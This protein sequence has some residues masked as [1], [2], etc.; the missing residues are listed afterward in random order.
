MKRLLTLL[1][2]CLLTCMVIGQQTVLLNEDFNSIASG[3]PSGWNNTEGTITGLNAG[4]NAYALSDNEGCIRF[5]SRNNLPGMTNMLKTPSMSFAQGSKMVL[6]FKYKKPNGGDFSIF[7][8]TDGGATYPNVLAN[9]LPLADDWVNKEYDL[10]G[11]AGNNN[12]KIVFKGTSNSGTGDAYIYLDDVVVE[13]APRCQEPTDMTIIGISPTSATLMWTLSYGG[14]QPGQFIITVT[15][16]NG[17]I[18]MQDSTLAVTPQSGAYYTTI[19]GL[20]ANTT[21]NVELQ[22]D[23]DAEYAGFSKK[24]TMTFATICESQALPYS[25]DFNNSAIPLCTTSHNAS[26]Y[27]QMLRLN[28]T[29]ASDA[30]IIFP[31]VAESAD[32]LEIDYRIRQDE[33]YETMYMVGIITDPADI[34]TFAPVYYGTLNDDD[35]HDIRFNTIG[36]MDPISPVSVCFYFGSGLNTTIYM[37][38]VNIHMAPGCFRPENPKVSNVTKNSATVEWEENGSINYTISFSAP[39]DT[40]TFTS[41]TSPY[42]ATGL[43]PNTHYTVTITANCG[44]DGNS[45][46]SRAIEIT[47]PC[48]IAVNA[49]FTEGFETGMIPD[50]WTQGSLTSDTCQ[51]FEASATVRHSG[52][53]AMKMKVMPDR[54]MSYLASQALPI[55]SAN[56]HQVT[57]WVNRDNNDGQPEEGI[58]I[59]ESQSNTSVANATLLGFIPRYYAAAPAEESAGWHKYSFSI[60]QSGTHYILIEGVHKNG[61]ELYFDDMSVELIPTCRPIEDI[62]SITTTTN[63]ATMSWT[64]NGTENQWIVVYNVINGSTQVAHDSTLVNTPSI[65]I[66][67]LDMGTDYS[68]SGSIY[69]Y[70]S[71]T[72]RSEKF[73]YSKNFST[74]CQTKQVPYVE[75]FE[76]YITNNSIQCWDISSSTTPTASTAATKCQ[77]FGAYRDASKESEQMVMRLEN[78][79]T[80]AGIA[81]AISPVI[82]LNAGTQY[83]VTF[84]F[85]NNMSR[86]R[87][88]DFISPV[89]KISIDNGVTFTV[90]DSLRSNMDSYMEYEKDL[91]AYAGHNVIFAFES[92]VSNGF[93]KLLIDNFQVTLKPLCADL[94]I[95]SISNVTSSS[96]Q[97]NITDN[98]GTAWEISY[99]TKGIQAGMGTTVSVTAGMNSGNI[100]GLTPQTEYDVYV[101]RNCGNEYGNWSRIPIRFTTTCIATTVPILEDFERIQSGQLKGCFINEVINNGAVGVFTGSENNHTIGGFNGI[102]GTLVS[103]S[104]SPTELSTSLSL[105][106]YVTLEAGKNYE[107][108]L[109]AKAYMKQNSLLDYNIRFKYGTLIDQANEIA[110]INVN[111]INWAKA[112]AYFTVPTDGDY[113]VGFTT[114]SG[115]NVTYYFIADDYSLKEVNCIPPTSAFISALA[116]NTA[117]ISIV[118]NASKYEVRVSDTEPD[119]N[120]EISG[121]I[122]LDAKCTSGIVNLTNLVPN[123][124]YYYTVRSICSDNV[125]SSEWL[126]VQTFHTRCGA[127][128]IPYTQDFESESSIS[129]WSTAGTGTALRVNNMHHSG[130]SSYKVN[131]LMLISP[132]F[133]TQTLAGNTFSG[134]VNTSSSCDVTIGLMNDPED[135]TSYAEVEKVHV[136]NNNMWTE[137]NVPLNLPADPQ[138]DDYRGAQY[139]V[140]ITE[141]GVTAYFDQFNFATTPTCAKPKDLT[142][143]NITTTS[144]M[145]DWAPQGTET[146]W[147]L[148][149]LS[150]KGGEG[151]KHIV[152]SHPYQLTGLNPGTTYKLYLKAVCSAQDISEETVSDPYSTL[153]GT[154]TPPFIEDFE[155]HDI[156]R[157]P[158]CWDTGSSTTPSQSSSYL[159][160]VFSNSSNK[161]AR[162][163]NQWVKAGIAELNTP[164]IALAAGSQ[165]VLQFD[166]AHNATCSDLAIEV[167]EGAQKTLI[168][169]VAPSGIDSEKTP[170]GFSTYSYD[171]SAFAGHN[172]KIAFLATANF[173]RGSIFLDNVEV[174]EVLNCQ[175]ISKVNIKARDI[176]ASAT[177]VDSVASHA[178]WQWAVGEIGF[179][180]SS[181]QY[182]ITTQ[183]TFQ[184]NGLQ[185][186]TEYE[187]YIRTECGPTDLSNWRITRFK[188][189]GAPAA[190]PYVCDF[191]DDE[192]IGKWIINNSETSANIFA[193]GHA[194]GAVK[195]GS[196]AL[197]VSQDGGLTY[198]YDID[199]ASSTAAAR[200]FNF[201]NGQYEI[202]FNWQCTGGMNMYDYARFYLVP[203][204]NGVE[205]PQSG[206]YYE[207]YYPANMIPLDGGIVSNVSGG[208]RMLS[209]T[210]DMTGRSGYYYLV[211]TWTNNDTYGSQSPLAINDVSVRKLTCQP[212]I[213][214][215]VKSVASNTATIRYQKAQRTVP[216]QWILNTIPSKEDPVATGA[217]ATDSTIELTGLQHSTHYYLYIANNCNGND[218]SKWISIDFTTACGTNYTYPFTEDF[219][220]SEFPP[221]CWQA[222]DNGWERYVPQYDYNDAHTGTA[223]AMKNSSTLSSPATHIDATREY[224]IKFWMKRYAETYMTSDVQLYLSPTRSSSSDGAVLLG[225]WT[226]YDKNL[227]SNTVVEI[228]VDV[229]A[230]ISTGDY[231]LLFEAHKN[232]GGLIIDDIEMLQYPA[233]RDFTTTPE[234]V[235]ISSTTMTVRIDKGLK[236]TIQF[237]WAPVTNGNATVA[238]TIGS[239][240]TLTDR[241][242]ITGL[243]PGGKYVVFARGLC[244]DGNSTAWSNGTTIE[245][246]TSDCFAPINLRMVGDVKATTVTIT[247]GGAPDATNYEYEIF[248]KN[249]TTR[250]TTA[251]DTVTVN[252]LTPTKQYNARVRTVCSDG[253]TTAWTS[254]SFE[255]TKLLAEVPYQTS[256]DDALD[257]NQWEYIQSTSNKFYISTQ[258]GPTTGNN[259]LYVSQRMAKYAVYSIALPTASNAN[260]AL[261]ISYARRAAHFEPG[262]YEVD[263]DWRCDA[264]KPGIN[265][266]SWEAFGRAFI[267]PEG[268][269]LTAD[270]QTYYS[271]APANS[272]AIYPGRMEGQQNWTTH[273]TIITI[274]KAGNYDIVFGWFGQNTRSMATKSDVGPAP[275]AIDNLNITEVSCLPV[276]NI[277]VT[278]R[279]NAEIKAAVDKSSETNLEYAV[280]EYE[281]EDSIKSG[282]IQT[283]SGDTITLTG[284]TAKQTYYLYVRQSC[285]DDDKSFWK[286]INFVVP[287]PSATLPYVCDFE[288]A[289]EANLWMTANGNQVNQFI[290]GTNDYSSATHSMYISNDGV[291]YAYSGEPAAVNTSSICYAY[292]TMHLEAGSYLWSY[293][294]KVKGETVH[295]NDYSRVFLAPANKELK[296]GTAL[297]GLSAS[298]IPGD[299]YQLDNGVMRY[300]ETWTTNEGIT[301]V[302]DEGDYNLVFFWLNDQTV[303]QNPPLAFD[304]VSIR[305]LNCLPTNVCCTG[306][307]ENSISLSFSGHDTSAEIEYTVSTTDTHD[308]VLIR[309]T[310]VPGTS[311][312]TINNLSA[313]T[314]YYIYTHVICDDDESP[315]K[316]IK[317]R[318]QCGTITALP[319]NMDFEMLNVQ[320][321]ATL[322]DICWDLLNANSY[323]AGSNS[324]YPFVNVAEAKLT[325]TT[326]VHS[327][328]RGLKVVT[329]S[330]NLYMVMPEI[331]DKSNLKLSFMYNPSYHSVFTIT[332]GYMTN[333]NDFSS[334]VALTNFTPI[335]HTWREAEE[336][337]PTLPDG[338]RITLRFNGNTNS[339]VGL[340]DIRVGKLIDGGTIID[341]VCYNSPYNENGFNVAAKD[342]TVGE[343][344]VSRIAKAAN[345]NVM[346]TIYYANLFMRQQISNLM[347]DTICEGVPYSSGLFNI[348]NPTTDQYTRTFTSTSTGCDSIVILNLYVVPSVIDIYDT[349]CHGEVY[350]FNDSS[351]TTAGIYTMYK[352]G[353]KGCY[354]YTTL[355]LTVADTVNYIS[356]T[357]CADGV[358]TF[359]G[360]NYTKAGTYRIVSIGAHGCPLVKI[361]TLNVL[362]SDTTYNANICAGGYLMIGDTMI[363]TAGTYHVKRMSRGGCF[364][365]H[366]VTVTVDD[367]IIN[368]YYSY[369]CEG[370]PIYEYGISGLV[371]TKDTVVTIN[372]KTID[373]M[374]DSTAIINLTFV[375]TAHSTTKMTINSGE[376]VEWNGTSYSKSGT[377]NA[378]ISTELGCDSV[379]T[380]ELTVIGEVGFDDI[381]TD[382]IVLYPNPTTGM[383]YINTD[384]EIVVK[385]M[386]GRIVKRSIGGKVDLTGLASGVYM[387][388]GIKVIKQ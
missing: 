358:Y 231:H 5:D 69:A 90:L 229:P 367:P 217:A 331:S 342:M 121:N 314:N 126:E 152:N 236:D 299:C 372:R 46:P 183:R 131:G 226:T 92:E 200:L 81:K 129:C 171:L 142:A 313:S 11:F 353:I 123:T 343:N 255:T 349:I 195:S 298:S 73:T 354:S 76:E 273:R 303:C 282:M 60:P 363:T 223:A 264:Y 257:N 370:K 173:Q 347:F 102:G 177:I 356:A 193:I 67:G 350:T 312:F 120:G 63:S 360:K 3:V 338:A 371:I 286:H 54:T 7:V 64:P 277:S 384:D 204:D 369:G 249:D 224:S 4:W 62:S 89:L 198:S 309:D 118:G 215:S 326:Y 108:S 206:Y 387:I 375:P 333:I 275:L 365:T 97:I 86:T 111:S 45:E 154:V 146:Q 107:I 104:Q 109:W 133:N 332:T 262:N 61:T 59:W 147:E 139:V 261:N 65:S 38:D 141:Q 98:A 240:T 179:K 304:N 201:E 119:A 320:Q 382:R 293:D 288:D 222:S 362:K 386:A 78:E 380:L 124:T 191:S 297:S 87:M 385:D 192:E 294:W 172:I 66:S 176:S 19:N 316:S 155:T 128:S 116:T 287:T 85:K 166:C 336:Y 151:V 247:W 359:E 268:L 162:L 186:E 280:I 135:L 213:S 125:S 55:P 211:F 388:N 216:T 47:T 178:K 144:M 150:T 161:M 271:A 184:I 180:L 305:K 167:V 245:L 196:K 29:T 265:M 140:I 225:T 345:A 337:F 250:G 157:T 227:L 1:V 325:D 260:T 208:W 84:D 22:G 182:N 72:D 327:G 383:V 74:K 205:V 160:G 295:V 188:T 138:Y 256:F 276:N 39:G 15:D 36:Q 23:C 381:E 28:P 340:D 259:S 344:T 18:I 43:T 230:G 158:R 16:V 218:P 6:K 31:L 214:A 25:A 27:N 2:G 181:Q 291:N 318:T 93:G 219:N 233:C 24:A 306:T 209:T 252:T 163:D 379:A 243:T 377:Y 203:A 137:F 115:A 190:M 351:I 368:T 311:T 32:N 321:N 263:F 234:I 239:M 153:C 334:F 79:G 267:V 42:T 174:R 242:A 149:V 156:D 70:C 52:N 237:A 373:G 68:V 53:K 130:S 278:K 290:V 329:C 207:S 17:S 175:D 14:K 185:P 307:T 269:E 279:T 58:K 376:S 48:D 296:A 187:L 164:E 20:T 346:D 170:K 110:V 341:T 56:T 238:D 284:L 9:D 50:C 169:S 253:S 281:S 357:I 289:T 335:G 134:W 199:V 8:S 322:S 348:P 94:R 194:Y 285:D 308:G 88:T 75:D 310:L 248:A 51:A 302:T 143:Y 148:F 77:I 127:V 378:V 83:R 95:S 315:W 254:I 100:T 272:I 319:Y 145:V 132:Q 266:N 235:N 212:V 189:S 82:A 251:N 317:V 168:G 37:D 339:F 21:Y 30:Y 364:V 244:V 91:S 324:S 228:T 361:L 35:W 103:G 274:T 33:T 197:Y 101:R 165:Y 26:I 13:S 122:Y 330:E 352:P 117:E 355:H 328:E 44:T 374:C 106:K 96:A 300:Q 71:T 323:N 40:K 80:M 10:Q 105:F 292:R 232:Y 57:L 221:T 210:I 246:P 283:V 136:R 99:G 41:T 113:F 366:H 220:G 12:V 270:A 258:A 112:K 202:E 301:Y 114:E 241:V 159:W 34:G 49:S